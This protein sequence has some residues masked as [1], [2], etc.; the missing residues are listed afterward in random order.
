[1]YSYAPVDIGWWG[2]RVLLSM[3]VSIKCEHMHNNFICIIIVRTLRNWVALLDRQYI[4]CKCV[5]KDCYWI[6]TIKPDAASIGMIS[7]S[8]PVQDGTFIGLKTGMAMGWD[9]ASFCSMLLSFVPAPNWQHLA[10]ILLTKDGFNR[11]YQMCIFQAYSCKHVLKL[12]ERDLII[13]I[14]QD[15]GSLWIDWNWGCLPP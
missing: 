13:I 4:P 15:L 2:N 14:F 7:S 8:V 3:T 1:M 5:L 11:I 10:A 6:G 9:I 12:Y